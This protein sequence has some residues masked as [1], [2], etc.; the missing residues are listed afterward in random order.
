MESFTS[1]PESSRGSSRTPSIILPRYKRKVLSRPRTPGSNGSHSRSWNIG[2]HN[3]DG[4][5]PLRKRQD[6]STK[7]KIV[8][9]EDEIARLREELVA[10]VATVRSLQ[11]CIKARDGQKGRDNDEADDGLSETTYPPTECQ[12][13]TSAVSAH[14]LA[15]TLS[16]I[17]LLH[18]KLANKL[19]ADIFEQLLKHMPSRKEIQRMIDAR[20]DKV[21]RKAVAKVVSPH[22]TAR[23]T[24]RDN[25]V[26]IDSIR[27]S[28]NTLKLR[29]TSLE[30]ETRTNSSSTSSL[31]ASLDSTVQSAVSRAT[32]ELRTSLESIISSEIESKTS[33][34]S[35]W[36]LDRAIASTESL[37]RE[38]V[39][40]V[41]H[42]SVRDEISTLEKT[43]K[44]RTE[45]M[46]RK[47]TDLSDRQASLASLAQQR[48]STSVVT[49]SNDHFASR[50]TLD[51]VSATLTASLT[52]IEERVESLAAALEETRMSAEDA[53]RDRVVGR[54]KATVSD[55]AAE[56][57]SGKAGVVSQIYVDRRIRDFEDKVVA[58]ASDLVR[59]KN[60]FSH[61]LTHPSERRAVYMWT[62][63]TLKLGSAIP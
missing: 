8:E 30:N 13:D 22:D 33:K 11:E 14:A 47:L 41:V 28:L 15:T 18:S 27:D 60:L 10:T 58:L 53:A 62:S 42:R 9:L 1:S 19:D 59:T 37:V 5:R 61:N 46:S 49:L 52:S 24:D 35:Q 40:S 63:G 39:D 31:F 6:A 21:V 26:V 7:P 51:T 36:T 3:R 25:N 38:R 44:R 56:M 23:Q 43:L 55:L 2:A 45:A 16:H 20:V 29:L 54:T 4:D 57:T 48:S 12:T 32:S 50:E 34:L 17:E